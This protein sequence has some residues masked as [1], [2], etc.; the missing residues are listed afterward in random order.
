M[1]RSRRRICRAPAPAL[2]VLLVLLGVLEVSCHSR[3]SVERLPRPQDPPQTEAAA[4]A[5][6]LD[7]VT[8]GSH[9]TWWVES[10]FVRTTG[11]KT[12]RSQITEVNR[13]PDHVVVGVGGATGVLRGTPLSCAPATGGPVCTGASGPGVVSDPTGLARLTDIAAGWYS[14]RHAP[15]RRVAGVAA[16]CFRMDRN[17]R[18]ASQSYGTRATLCYSGEGIPVTLDVDRP[19]SADR[20]AAR[21]VQRAVTDAA[22]DALVAPFAG[23]GPVRPLAPGTSVVPAVPPIGS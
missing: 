16:Q 14:L 10:T 21:S 20:I 11:G 2:V 22:L 17:G 15:A 7:L 12:L 23:V 19:A 9:T 13:P 8:R 4:R 18:S 5:S 6:F 3:S 1:S